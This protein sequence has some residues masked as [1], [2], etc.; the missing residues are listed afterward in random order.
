MKLFSRFPWGRPISIRWKL[1]AIISVVVT[2][3]AAVAA[4]AVSLQLRSAGRAAA[5][6]AD[7]VATAIANTVHLNSAENIRNAQNYVMGLGKVY[8]RDIAILDR[9]GIIVAGTNPEALGTHYA[10]ADVQKTLRDGVSRTFEGPDISSFGLTKQVVVP[11]RRDPSL[12]DSPVVGVVLYEYALFYDTLMEEAWRV[13]TLTSLAALFLLGLGVLLA[14]NVIHSILQPL[15]RLRQG[16]RAI[17]AGYFDVRVQVDTRDEL[18]HLADAFNGMAKELEES[19]SALQNEI[20]K[21][22]AAAQRI[23]YLAYN[24]QLTALP[25]R[26]MF[27]VALNQALHEAQRHARRFALLFVDL[28]RFKHINDTLGHATGDALLK[29]VALRLGEALRAGDMV[30]RLG[31]DEF[32]VLI[33]DLQNEKHV[34]IVAEKILAAIAVPLQFSGHELRVTCSVGVSIYPGDGEDA[35][36]LMKNAD[37]AMYQAKEKGRNHFA[38]YSAERDVNTFE[39][40]ALETSLRR[41]VDRDE[42]LLYYQPKMDFR[43][44]GTA[45][46]EAL[47]R[48]QHPEMGMI[49]PAQFIPLAEETGLIVPI[50]MWVLRTACRQMVQW[51]E[52]GIAQL[53]ISVNL[54]PRQFSD[55]NLL[56][57]IAAT[58]A[59]TGLDGRCLELEITESAIMQDVE[60]GRKL[61]MALKVMGIRIAVDDFGT[62]YSSLSTLKQFPIDTLKIDRS[63]IRDLA[64]DPEDR[65]LTE[66][67]I[68]M[69]K[70]LK[71]HLV[72]E[73]VETQA[74]LDFLRE[75]GCDELQGYHFSRPLPVDQFESFVVNERRRR[76]VAPLKST[77]PA[78]LR[79]E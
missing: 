17:S 42:L 2:C 67:I 6:E 75:R 32:V 49:S 64:T 55:S 12:E 29:D 50:G 59:E 54:S 40:L 62:G 30:A 38:F 1:M 5:L 15:Q 26:T 76:A 44:G 77:Q 35:Q 71:L 46:M 23:E 19:H 52:Q 18:G 36:T 28:D 61:L 45:G 57:D 31:G 37:I 65:G 22:K 60:R 25:N 73:G 68:A 69:G 10:H 8:E 66:A 51:R 3:V 21:Q 78:S 56:Q 20:H 27:S 16:V 41:A 9:A 33:K 63:F 47:V 39:R 24:D 13:A 14:G 74:Q 79:A 34:E 72:A 11:L 7:H 4:V 58:L 70:A 48:W 43:N 53:V